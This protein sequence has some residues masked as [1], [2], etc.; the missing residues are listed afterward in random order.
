MSAVPAH[1]YSAPCRSVAFVYRRRRPER[2]ALYRLVQQHLETWLARTRKTDPDGTPVARHI[3][4]ELRAYLE[5]GILACGF[6]RARCDACGHDFLVAFSCKGR[7]LCPSCTT[8]RMAATAAHLVEHVFPKVPV[9]QWVVSFPRRLRYFLHRDP[10]LLG[11]VRR[12]VLRTIEVALR[13]RCPD[14]PRDSRCGAVCFVQRFGSALNAHTHLHD[15]LTDGVFSVGPDG[16][17]RFHRAADFD[18]AAVSAVERRIRSRV[19]RIAVRYGALT[20]EVAADL[21]RWSHG[22]G[23]SLHAGVRIEAA[24]RAGLERLLRY[25]AQ[26]AFASERLSWDGSDQPV[27][28]ARPKPLPSGQTAL[29]LAP[30]ELL[31]R[32]AALIPPPRRHWHHDAGVYAPHAAL[33]ARVT[34]CAAKPVTELAPVTVPRTDPTLPVATRRRASLSCARLL[35]C[36]YE[37]QPLSCPRCQG[38]MRLIAFLTEPRSIRAL[39]A[40]LGEPTTP[41]ALAPR[42]RAPPELEP[43]RAGTPAFAFDQ[44]PPWDP[45]TPAPDPGLPFDQTLN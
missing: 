41:P 31:D 9:R 44:S 26:P 3:E 2:T 34:A 5:C 45:I 20:P 29:T 30:L 7:G 14:A 16:T 18:A 13:R 4:R 25:C 35:A 32:L 15:C 10:V 17:L 33:R 28:Y 1:L 21:A 38:P 37:L 11:R 40:H 42:A 27:R 22:G 36:I 19:L 6:A 24:D 12:C 23:F 43:E 39:L 8:R